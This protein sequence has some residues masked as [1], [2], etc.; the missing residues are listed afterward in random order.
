MPFDLDAVRAQFPALAIRDSD[1][2]R[3]YFDN[4]AGT[5]VPTSVV[6]AM[7]DCLLTSSANL[8]GNFPTSDRA[9]EVVAS[10]R[11]AMAD[12]I[13]APSHDEIIFGQNMTTLT[14]ALSRAMARRW[15]ADDEVIVGNIAG[16]ADAA[17]IGR[18]ISL[19]AKVPQHVPAFTVNRNC[20]SGLESIVEAAYRIRAGEAELVV[21]A[22]VESMSQIP[23][24]TPL[25]KGL[26]A[27]LKRRG[28]RF[29]GPTTAYAF[30]QAMGL[31][32][33]HTADCFARQAAERARRRFARPTRH[34]GQ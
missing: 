17:N 14:F 15:S 22:A 10:A 21:A 29:V 18:V 4:P 7:S 19:M 30:M 24:E 27:D 5:Q 16:P 6:A 12:L 3:V 28:F 11:S 31:V 25:G 8:G 34:E 26:S 2:P 1:M 20:A 33:D 23:A 9:D 32:N 13:N